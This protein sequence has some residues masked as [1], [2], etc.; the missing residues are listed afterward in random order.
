MS[1]LAARREAAGGLPTPVIRFARRMLPP[2]RRVTGRER[3]WIDPSRGVLKRVERAVDIAAS[4]YLYPHLFGI[5][6]PYSWQLPRRLLVSEAAVAPP[7][8]PSDVPP[9]RVLLLT[10]LHVG[11][12]LRPEVVADVLRELMRLEPDLVAIGGDLIA[13]RAHDLGG[14]LDAIEIV[15]SAPLGAWFAMGN[16]EYF[17]PDPFLVIEQLRSVGIPTLRNHAV[18]IGHGGASFVLGG[19]DDRVLGA[20]D[21]DRLAASCGAPHLLLAHNPDDFYEAERRG[22]ALVLAGHTHGGQIRVPGGPPLVRQSR[23]C[24]DE[25]LIRYG[26]ALLAVS[27]GIGASGLPWRFGARPEALLLTIAAAADGRPS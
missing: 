12:F 8:W 23:F 14:F 9:L 26:D 4:R 16:H 13:G 6:S 17:S 5:W 7:R 24:L 11:A 3:R 25:G 19:I 20:P 22:V 2:P 10:D 18:R 15:R 27:R 1:A 21:W